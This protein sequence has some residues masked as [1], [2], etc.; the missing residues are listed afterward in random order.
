MKEIKLTEQENQLLRNALFTLRDKLMKDYEKN[1]MNNQYTNLE[2]KIRFI[3]Y[4]IDIDKMRQKLE[5]E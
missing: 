5:G 1:K 4:I 2:E 3:E